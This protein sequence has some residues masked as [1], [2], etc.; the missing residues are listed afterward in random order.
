MRQR[1]RA[2]RGHFD[3]PR[4]AATIDRRSTERRNQRAVLSLGIAAIAIAL[5]VVA[6]G[7]YISRVRTPSHVV[8]QVGQTEIELRDLIPYARIVVGTDRRHGQ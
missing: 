6:A 8:A 5:I 2:Q 3:A 4:S 7:F 1:R